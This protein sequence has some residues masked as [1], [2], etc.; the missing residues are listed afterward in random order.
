MKKWQEFLLWFVCFAFIYV[1][2]EFIKTLAEN[3]TLSKWTFALVA[4]AMFVVGWIAAF[5]GAK[6][7]KSKKTEKKNNWIVGLIYFVIVW[8]V[9]MTF[10]VM[11]YSLENNILNTYYFIGIGSALL[12]TG[13]ACGRME[14]VLQKPKKRK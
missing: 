8:S 5:I 1:A 14:T 9:C 12:F 6:S 11:I 10:D 4:L 13:W 7:L 2:V 3:G